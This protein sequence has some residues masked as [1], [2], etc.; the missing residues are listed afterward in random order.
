ML[1]GSP[2]STAGSRL[3]LAFSEDVVGIRN[4]FDGLSEIG[5]CD[6]AEIGRSALTLVCCLMAQKPIN[7]DFANVS[8]DVS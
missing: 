1:N 6:A 2:L 5:R 7:P 8:G 3:T 4:R